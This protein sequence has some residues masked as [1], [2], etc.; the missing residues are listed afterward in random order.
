MN[1]QQ[2]IELLEYYQNWRRGPE[3]DMPE[4]KLLG[5]AIDVI[6]THLKNIENGKTS[7]IETS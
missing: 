4:P 2:A 5:E 7:I 1:L 6:L 3:I